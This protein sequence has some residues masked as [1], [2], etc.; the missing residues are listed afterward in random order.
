MLTKHPIAMNP[1][2]DETARM[3]DTPM[4]REI[5]LDAMVERQKDQSTL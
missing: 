5:A 1:F 4:A 3:A 2:R